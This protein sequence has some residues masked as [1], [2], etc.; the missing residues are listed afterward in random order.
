MQQFLWLNIFNKTVEQTY[1]WKGDHIREEGIIRLGE[2]KKK[3]D[4]RP[5]FAEIWP[6]D[7][8]FFYFI[9]IFSKPSL[10]TFLE[11]FTPY[12]YTLEEIGLWKDTRQKAILYII[13]MRFIKIFFL[14]RK[15]MAHYK[16]CVSCY[17]KL[18]T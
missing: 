2:I 4:S 6:G 17:V 13:A 9:F 12:I 7:P 11:D 16:N 18:Y 5:I 14:Q 10:V 3:L 1:F 8:G 15:I